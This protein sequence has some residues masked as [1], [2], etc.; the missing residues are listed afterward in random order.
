VARIEGD[1]EEGA[2]DGG[3]ASLRLIARIAITWR[4]WTA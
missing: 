3:E 1:F 2:A 4:K